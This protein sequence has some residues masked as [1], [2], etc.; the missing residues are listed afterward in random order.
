MIN[1]TGL[2]KISPQRAFH[3][4]ILFLCVSVFLFAGCDS[5]ERSRKQLEGK[6]IEFSTEAFLERIG[7][8]NS[9]VIELFLKAGMDPNAEGKYGETALMLAAVYH[10]KE[11]VD[12]LAAH[13]A[14]V[15]AKNDEGYTAL[16]FI[17]SQGNSDMAEFLIRKG[18]DVDAQNNYGE[19]PLMLA[20]LN[21]HIDMV[22]LL[23]EKGADVER[24]NTMGHTALRYAFLNK[25]MVEVLKQ[26]IMKK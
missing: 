26:A 1:S 12:L 4:L 18:A 14:R 25:Q 3:T 13:G 9:E 23:L 24:K 17:A 5:K 2:L 8:E 15:N 22:R 21:D 20:I 11:F 16:M 6:G 10:K 19:T 7:I